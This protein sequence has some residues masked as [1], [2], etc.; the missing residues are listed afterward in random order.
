MTM[1]DFG[2]VSRV[3]PV[4]GWLLGLV[5][6]SLA[7]ALILQIFPRFTLSLTALL[8]WFFAALIARSL[9]LDEAFACFCFG[10]ADS[11]LSGWTLA[12]TSA[13]AILATIVALASVPANLQLSFQNSTLQATVAW[14][15]LGT[16]VLVSYVPQLLR[17]GSNPFPATEVG[18]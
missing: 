18:R 2:I 1:V 9:W 16:I 10:D 11:E 12:R 6:L 5:E 8:L 17:W 3:Q 15:L 14:S 13:L 7:L 4:F